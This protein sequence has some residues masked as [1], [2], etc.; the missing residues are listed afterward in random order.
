MV[1]NDLDYL[2]KNEEEDGEEGQGQPVSPVSSG[3]P[4]A[5]NPAAPQAQQQG[6]QPER[7][8]SGKFTNIKKYVDAN[9]SG[10][11]KLGEGIQQKIGSEADK[12]REGIQSAQG[13]FQQGA[14]QTNQTLNK[15][16]GYAQK[17]GQVG[18]AQ[19]IADVEPEFKT[20]RDI[21][22]GQVKG[23]DSNISS[24]QQNAA[25]LQ[26]LSQLAGNESGRFQLLDE[27]YTNPA[28][29]Y[30][31]GQKRFDQLLLQAT[32]DVTKNLQKFGEQQATD[33][34]G[35]Y[36]ATEK[37]QQAEV[38]RLMDLGLTQKQALEKAT[39][40]TFGE[41]D[42]G[43]LGGLYTDLSGA[44]KSATE[45]QV[46]DVE[47]MKNVLSKINEVKAGG[48]QGKITK[49]QA[50]LLNLDPNMR[51]YGLDLS[52]FA[53]NLRIADTDITMGDI[54]NQE[55]ESRLNALY[56]LTGQ[57][58]SS[59]NLGEKSGRQGVEIA[60]DIGNARDIAERNWINQQQ[61]Q[62]RD[63]FIYDPTYTGYGAGANLGDRARWAERYYGGDQGQRISQAFDPAISTLGEAL[64]SQ[65]TDANYRQIFAD[66]FNKA[67]TL[68]PSFGN[69]MD[70]QEDPHYI[71]TAKSLMD[72]YIPGTSR[73]RYGNAASQI[74][75]F[76]TA[77]N[78]SGR[79]F[80]EYLDD[81]MKQSTSTLTGF[82]EDEDS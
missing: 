62:L 5:V 14:Q 21:Y 46:A 26:A 15:A 36:A 35:R 74:G 18:G 56:R 70:T 29:A 61:K 17:V 47:N 48:A 58:P 30:T 43:A 57:D 2:G 38:K 11:Q 55:Q 59:I 40:K 67:P 44:Q 73:D 34:Q 80:R 27:T 81:I 9:L 78:Y 68:T 65:G 12:V 16:T 42:T 53:P 13:Q 66:A 75:E 23:P 7:K 60:E 41:G 28:Q 76:G 82:E 1:Y 19:Q 4:G 49:D 8:G 10:G 32:P 22:T 39:G 31:R 54:S 69:F 3:Q 24:Q 6:A 33:V 52:Q 63:T 79:T 72:N 20:F 25:K 77:Y 50:A 51:T 64:S 37:E 71:E 45:K